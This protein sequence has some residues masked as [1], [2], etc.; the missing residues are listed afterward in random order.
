MQTDDDTCR[1]CEHAIYENPWDEGKPQPN[2]IFSESSVSLTPCTQCRRN[3]GAE[4]AD[5]YEKKKG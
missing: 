3:P 1:G 2:F 5:N 4:L